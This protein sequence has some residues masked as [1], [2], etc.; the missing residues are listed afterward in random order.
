[1]LNAKYLLILKENILSPKNTCFTLLE[2]KNKRMK[3]ICIV[4]SA[5]A[6]ASKRCLTW[7]QVWIHNL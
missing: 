4:I 5:S 1:M 2:E 6:M 7:S 3:I